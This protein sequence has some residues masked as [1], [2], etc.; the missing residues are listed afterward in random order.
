MS[1]YAAENNSNGPKSKEEIQCQKQKHI[2][3]LVET[4]ENHRK[5]TEKTDI[6]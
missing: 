4:E 2:Q 6:V 5:E 3:K 1:D